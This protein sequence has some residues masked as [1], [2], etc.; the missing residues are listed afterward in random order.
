[1]LLK[2]DV[3]HDSAPANPLLSKLTN[4]TGGI[5]L[6]AIYFP[7]RE[8]PVLLSSIY[9]AATLVNTLAHPDADRGLTVSLFGWIIHLDSLPVV[10]ALA[11]FV[12]IIFNLMPCVLPVLPL[13][14]MSF[15]ETAQ[16][17]R[18]KSVLLSLWFSGG[19]IFT[20]LILALL[21]VVLHTLQWGQ[22]FGK[23]WFIW[24]IVAILVAL[25]LSMMAGQ[26]IRLPNAVYSITP[27]HETYTGN[28]LFGILAAVLSTPCTA[29]MFP[30]VLIWAAAQPWAVGTSAIL[31]VGVGMAAPYVLLSAFPEVA[32]KFP[33]TGPVSE[34]IK[35]MMGFL[36]LAAAAFFAGSR[37]LVGSSVWWPVFAVIVAS[38]IYLVARTARLMPR[39]RPVVVASVIAVVMV[40]LSLRLIL[41]AT[42]V[43]G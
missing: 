20:F 40:G 13:K 3:T 18:H 4:G 29:P 35:Q 2:G 17:D 21:V 7:G 9:Q 11:F 24:T 14:I 22:L 1:M 10:L 12:G 5:P 6:T 27:R 26:S 15:Y 32:R 16:H 42:G 43:L 36:L 34:L 25:A 28:F 38:G 31:M 30:P 8:K 19:I 23:A 41:G 39:P 37:F 33:R